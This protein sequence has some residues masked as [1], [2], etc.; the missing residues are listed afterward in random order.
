MNTLDYTYASTQATNC[1]KCGECKHTPLHNDT[2]GGYVCLTCI[3][4]ELEILQTIYRQL[5]E[6]TVKA[7]NLLS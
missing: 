6:L 2:M 1:A 5:K 3:D 7:D 4:K